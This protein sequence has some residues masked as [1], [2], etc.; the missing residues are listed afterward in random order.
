MNISLNP[1]PKK[2]SEFISHD[3][4]E[5]WCVPG[6]YIW[7]WK[8][9]IWYVG[10]SESNVWKRNH[11]HAILQSSGAYSLP[12]EKTPDLLKYTSGI[13]W[14][15]KGYPSNKKNA[16]YLN[17]QLFCELTENSMSFRNETD[18]YLVYL[19]PNDKQKT[20]ENTQIIKELESLLISKLKPTDNRTQPTYASEALS[21]S[22]EIDPILKTLKKLTREKEIVAKTATKQAV[23]DEIKAEEEYS[24]RDLIREDDRK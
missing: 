3:A 16:L 4:D 1:N 5:T 13:G 14:N 23:T 17:H 22:S 11:V 9:Q 15:Q 20:K 7:I 18:V 12:F 19:N 10:K 8:K 21:Q 2:L 24:I 6:V